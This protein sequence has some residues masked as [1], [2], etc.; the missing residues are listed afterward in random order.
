MAIYIDKR[1]APSSARR[2]T[3]FLSIRGLDVLTIPDCLMNDLM[4]PRRLYYHQQNAAVSTTCNASTLFRSISSFLRLRSCRYLSFQI[5]VEPSIESPKEALCTLG[6]NSLVEPYLLGE[7][8]GLG[9]RNDKKQPN[10]VRIARY[11]HALLELGKDHVWLQM[12]QG[13]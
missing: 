8:H 9:N 4:I 1:Y 2:Q 7:A 12:R 5:C 13:S 11:H 6:V 3:C 10:S